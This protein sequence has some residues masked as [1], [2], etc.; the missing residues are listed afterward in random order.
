MQLQKVKKTQFFKYLAGGSI[1]FWM[2]Y[3]IFAALYS[4]LHWDW[5]PS[6]IVAD[7]IGWTFNYFAQR[8]W[9]FSSD[10]LRLGE[11]QHVKRYIAIESVGFG[12]DYL[13]I[14]GLNAVGISPYI[15][16]CVSGVFFTIWSYLWYKYWVFPEKR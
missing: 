10:H 8:Y 13:I 11:M 4:G 2:G 3:A 16:F 9:A 12:I 1:Y 5:L 15:G 7:T 14:Y 6:K